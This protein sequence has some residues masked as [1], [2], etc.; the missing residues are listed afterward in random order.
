MTVYCYN[1]KLRKLL[2]DIHLANKKVKVVIVD[3]IYRLHFLPFCYVT[4][5][6]YHFDVTKSSRFS[7]CYNVSKTPGHP[8]LPEITM[9]VPYP[10]TL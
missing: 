2:T 8:K 5:I 6:L 9:P 10:G 4:S 7:N 1:R 3:N